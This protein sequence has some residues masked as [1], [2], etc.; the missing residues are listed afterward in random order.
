MA[1]TRLSTKGQIVLPHDIRTA[2]N[3]APGTQLEIER[4]G[5]AVVLRPKR[6]LPEKVLEPRQVA[7]M[8]KWR[9]KTVSIEEMD[10]AIGDMFRREWKP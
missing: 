6:T 10:E 9:G 4:K 5:D 1:S 8:L 3:W 7:G 2:M